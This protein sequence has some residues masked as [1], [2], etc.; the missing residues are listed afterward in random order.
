M[1][2]AISENVLLLGCS[3]SP[4]RETTNAIHLTQGVGKEAREGSSQRPSAEEDGEP[5]LYLVTSVPA[6]QKIGRGREEASLDWSV[7]HAP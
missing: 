4:T 7:R 1:S 6:G 2:D 5:S 3:P